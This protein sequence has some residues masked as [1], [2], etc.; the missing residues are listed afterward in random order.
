[1][2]RSRRQYL[3]ACI[4]HI[5]MFFQNSQPR[6]LNDQA[7]PLAGWTL[8]EVEDIPSTVALPHKIHMESSS[9]I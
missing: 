5:R 2:V 1:M 4:K 7:D 3:R 8:W 6:P 9:L